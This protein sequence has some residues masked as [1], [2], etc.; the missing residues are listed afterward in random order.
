MY[1]A[2]KEKKIIESFI[3]YLSND[4]FTKEKGFNLEMNMNSNLIYNMFDKPQ[5][6]IKEASKPINK[7]LFEFAYRNSKLK[8]YTDEYD[9][10]KT[11]I[12]ETRLM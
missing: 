4:I 9:E 6:E 11:D 1:I 7:E 8:Y 5:N 2:D 10:N 3:K 12:I